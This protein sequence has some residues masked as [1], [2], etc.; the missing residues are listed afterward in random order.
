MIIFTIICLIVIVVL[1]IVCY[2]LFAIAAE[3]DARADEMY[4]RWKR[5]GRNKTRRP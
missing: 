5:D 4:E 3:A 1:L 2:A